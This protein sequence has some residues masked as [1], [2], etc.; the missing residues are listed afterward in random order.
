MIFTA[1]SNNTKER[2]I[3]VNISWNKVV[4]GI[5]LYGIVIATIFGNTLV[6]I[7]VKIDRKL[8]TSFNYFIVNLA[9]TDVAVAVTAMSFQAT[10]MVFGYWPFGEV[11]CAAWIF[12]DYG[13]RISF[14]LLSFRLL[15]SMTFVSV[16]TL[17]LISV[18]RFW[19]VTW[20]Y[21]YRRFHT[22]KRCI[23]SMFAIWAFMLV[24]WVPPWLLDR[25]KNSSPNECLWDPSL[26][27][28]LVYVVAVLGHHLPFIT[29]LYCYIHVAIYFRNKI[30]QNF[31]IY[32]IRQSLQSPT[33]SASQN[34]DKNRETI[35]TS[36]D[37]ES[38]T[39][40]SN[41]TGKA[42]TKCV[43]FISDEKQNTCELKPQHKSMTY[44]RLEKEKKI[45]Y[46]LQLIVLSYAL[47]WFPFHIVFDIS[48]S[49]PNLVPEIFWHVTFWMTYVNSTV[50]PIVY[51]L[52]SPAQIGKEITMT[53]ERY[54]ENNS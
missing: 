34:E 45:F 16:F 5:V 15:H 13:C 31:A 49:K 40:D 50:N 21:N 11:L 42:H 28:E 26:N 19:S 2:D 17:I 27:Q 52:S 33:A 20:S 39:N 10:H 24:L 29:I 8:Q 37:T 51:T 48:I 30:K 1:E 23:I 18:D 38:E 35:S 54:G 41:R 47:L 3:D 7:A 9:I 25:L 4:V 14:I 32:R 6:L 36:V 44:R 43:S 46:S 12:F 22:K 53:A